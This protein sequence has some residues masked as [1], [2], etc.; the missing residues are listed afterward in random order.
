MWLYWFLCLECTSQRLLGLTATLDLTFNATSS[1]L[2]TPGLFAPQQYAPI[3]VYID[4]SKCFLP[5][6]KHSI[7]YH[8]VNK[9]LDLYLAYHTHE[10]WAVTI[11]SLKKFSDSLILSL[12]K[13]WASFYLVHQHNPLS[14]TVPGTWWVAM[15]TGWKIFSY[16]TQ[17]L[18]FRALFFSFP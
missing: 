17:P 18:A 8:M 11:L 5:F 1:V 7:N 16:C 15:N 13:T 9:H 14:S 6:H 3:W 4:H 10:I 12:T 2:P